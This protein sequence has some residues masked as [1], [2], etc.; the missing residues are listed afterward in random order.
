M[1][2]P[3]ALSLGGGNNFRGDVPLN[4]PLH[5]SPACS[6]P[7]SPQMSPCSLLSS[8]G[9]EKNVIPVSVWILA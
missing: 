4:V 8:P 1:T 2:P 6:C 3:E 5:V 9:A 7:C